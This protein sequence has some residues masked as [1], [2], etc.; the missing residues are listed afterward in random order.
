MSRPRV[1]LDRDVCIGAGNCVLAAPKAFDLD[2]DGVV[3]L[4]DP[5][6][7]S[8]EELEQAEGSC[9]SGAIRLEPG[10]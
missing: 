7:A 4:L 3:V 2:D 1:V 5:D 9:P 8:P 10:D 6:A